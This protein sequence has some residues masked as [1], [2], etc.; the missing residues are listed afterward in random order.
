MVPPNSGQLLLQVLGKRKRQPLFYKQ[1]ATR[2]S[3]AHVWG[4][5]EN[6]R[7]LTTVS[8]GGIM[9]C[10]KIIVLIMFS[11]TFH[12]RA[13]HERVIKAYPIRGVIKW[14]C[15]MITLPVCTPTGTTYPFWKIVNYPNNKSAR[16][17]EAAF[18]ESLEKNYIFVPHSGWTSF[19]IN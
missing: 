1:G 15:A 10:A 4:K 3:P 5:Y 14:R 18:K 7:T 9:Y 11:S 17:S 16:A 2:T 12:F 13:N 6:I 19:I 8:R